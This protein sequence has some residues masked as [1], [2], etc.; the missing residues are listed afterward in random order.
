MN[1]RIRFQMHR[2]GLRL[3]RPAP[4]VRATPENIRAAR[5]AR[6]HELVIDD[7]THA[8]RIAPRVYCDRRLDGWLPIARTLYTGVIR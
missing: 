8:P 7:T 2:M 6:D 5:I 3:A 1:A 4:A